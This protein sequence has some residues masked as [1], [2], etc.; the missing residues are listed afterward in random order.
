MSKVLR[1]VYYNRI[2]MICSQIRGI[3]HTLRAR[4][5]AC[6]DQ[7]TTSGMRNPLWRKLLQVIL[8]SI[9]L[10]QENDLSPG[11]FTSLSSPFSI[12]DEFGKT[13][14]YYRCIETDWTSG[15]QINDSNG[16]TEKS[17]KVTCTCTSYNSQWYSFPVSNQ[18]RK[19]NM[20][21][22]LIK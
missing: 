5:F 11:P 1:P 8:G 7:A 10:N 13:R 12:S 3:L 6:N 21:I 9:D 22:V 18:R 17:F 16:I 19:I 2:A 4:G 14:Q 20:C 15:N